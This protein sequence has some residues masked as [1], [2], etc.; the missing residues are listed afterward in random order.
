MGVDEVQTGIAGTGVVGLI[1]G[2]GSGTR[3]IGVRADMDALP[4]QEQT[5]LT[6]ASKTEA[7][8]PLQL[9]LKIRPDEIAKEQRSRAVF[10]R[11]LAALRQEI[12]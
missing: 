11:L 8:V 4:I 10:P 12:E 3:R 7:N 1:H 2:S 5:N 9:K 6:Y